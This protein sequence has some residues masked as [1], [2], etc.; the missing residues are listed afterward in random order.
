ML[1]GNQHNPSLNLSDLVFVGISHIHKCVVAPDAGTLEA[2]QDSLCS[3]AELQ[4]SH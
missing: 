2:L 4:D 1:A 3:D